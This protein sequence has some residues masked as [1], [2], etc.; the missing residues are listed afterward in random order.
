MGI[1][2]RVLRASGSASASRFP[3]RL[4]P[5]WTPPGAASASRLLSWVREKPGEPLMP[6]C[7]SATGRERAPARKRVERMRTWEREGMTGRG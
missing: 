6:G 5:P 2:S 4:K 3:P 7:G 1:D